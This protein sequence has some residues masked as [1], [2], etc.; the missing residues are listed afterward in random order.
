MKVR[1]KLFNLQNNQSFKN[2]LYNCNETQ[3]YCVGTQT[4]CVGLGLTVWDLGTESCEVS[5]LLWTWNVRLLHSNA[6]DSV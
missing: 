6:T 2:M 3:I 1:W 5:T 4:Y